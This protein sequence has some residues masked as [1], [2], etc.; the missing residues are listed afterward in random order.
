M[1]SVELLEAQAA[2]E[3]AENEA[4]LAELVLR[5]AQARAR[6]ASAKAS[7]E[8]LQDPNRALPPSN[9]WLEAV[10]RVS[11]GGSGG[12]SVTDTLLSRL[13]EDAEY[14]REEAT[15]RSV[16]ARRWDAPITSMVK[17]R[18][19]FKHFYVEAL[20]AVRVSGVAR[21][22]VFEDEVWHKRQALT[23][24]SYGAFLE[25]SRDLGT[26]PPD[27]YVFELMSP[28]QVSPSGPSAGHIEDVDETPV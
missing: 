18:Q 20:S 19:S 4:A 2:A 11:A 9:S 5:T 13:L 27:I 16:Q 8:A 24:E 3:A 10:P 1:P 28:I 23:A 12:S 14:R 7:L 6:T 15:L 25:K 21:L 17:L 22:Y 26:I